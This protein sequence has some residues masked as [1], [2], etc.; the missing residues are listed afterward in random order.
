MTC[1]GLVLLAIF[2]FFGLFDVCVLLDY[3]VLL[4]A[5]VLRVFVFLSC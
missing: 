4:V 2:V 1:A 5:L 3:S